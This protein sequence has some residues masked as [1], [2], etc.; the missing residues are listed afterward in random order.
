MA[1]SQDLVGTHYRYPDHYVVGREK[2]REHAEAV[3][4]HYPA[5][6]D[7]AGAAELGHSAL[8]APP[9]F[10]A[11]FGYTAQSAFFEDANIGIKDEKIVQVDQAFKYIRPVRS[12]DTLYCDVYV[13]SIRRS[14]GTD[15]I[16]IKNIITNDKGEFVTESYTTLAGRA[17]DDGEEGGFN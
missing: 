10:L 12:G 1:L 6:H 16:V 9:T 5:H 8:V 15:I 14:F 3:K 4:C 2:I 11:V 7:E 17:E 13:D